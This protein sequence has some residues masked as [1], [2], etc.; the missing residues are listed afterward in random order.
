MHPSSS[1]DSVPSIPASIDADAQ[2]RIRDRVPVAVVDI[3]SNSVRLVIY[4]GNSR[5]PTIL[6]NEKVLSGLGRGL[7][8]TNRLDDKAVASAIGALTRFR[9]LCRQSGVGEVHPIATAAAREAT[10]GPD[11]I[12]AAEAAIGCPIT[13]LSGADEARFAAEG[14]MAGFHAPSGFAGDLGG[15]SLEI[16][17]ISNG[18]I[19]QGITMPLGGLR[20]QDLSGN[21]P[22]KARAI[23]DSHVVASGFGP[24]AAGRPFFAV[25]GTWR[26]L[27]RLH[28]EQTG[29]PLHVMHGY[30]VKAAD[31]ADFLGAVVKSD[32]EKLPGIAAVSRSRRQL[33][34]F[35]AVAMQAV[36]QHLKPSEIVLSAY[37]VREGY[38]HSRLSDEDKAKDPLIEAAHELSVLRS[39]SPRHNEELVEWTNR[40]FAALGIAETLDEARLRRAACLLTDISWRAHPDYRGRQSMSIIVNANFPAVDHAGRAYLGL[41][42]YYRYEGEFDPVALNVLGQAVDTRSLHLARV[43][44]SLFRVTYLLTAA[45]PGVLGR[46]RWLQDPRGGFTLAVP[47]ELAGLIGERPEAR[48]QAF[49]RIVDRTLRME[50]R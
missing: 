26:N 12:R 47:R 39:R 15:G 33:L 20:L 34:A 29:Y 14:V 48:L 41:A 46:L 30:T 3:G 2:G 9:A 4:E 43:L 5:A 40:T 17:E 10:N 38:L 45:M 35:G 6:F 25:G 23:A 13:I 11:F 31:A 32:P 8:Q 16:V 36:V 42:N 21:D 44:A 49:S 50:A 22:A 1:P 7:A 18:A 27:F 28:M 24:L 19:G 37:G